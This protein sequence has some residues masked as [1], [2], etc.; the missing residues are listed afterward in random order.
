MEK[1]KKIFIRFLIIL[2][3]L[4]SI[5]GGTSFISSGKIV[6]LLLSHNNVN[7]AEVPHKHHASGLTDDDKLIDNISYNFFTV[8]HSQHNFLL[9]QETFS[10]KYAGSVWQPPE[11]L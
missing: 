5:D 10:G 9:N 11:S 8:Y 6:Q 7:D 4:L 2:V 1:G 3:S